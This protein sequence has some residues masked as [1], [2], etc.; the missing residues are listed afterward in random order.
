VRNLAALA[1]NWAYYRYQSHL[2][3][4][5]NT[6]L[7]ARKI[8][9]LLP[10]EALPGALLVAAAVAAMIVVNSPLGNAYQSV[11]DAP[12]LIGPS[13][14][15][16][17]MKL[18]YWIKNGLMAIFFFFVGL[19][20]KRELLEGQLSN[21]RAAVLP[22]LGA[23]GGMVAPAL[24]YIA[25]AGPAG[26]GHGWAIPAAT[27]IAFALGVLSLLGKRVP[28]ALKAFLLAVAVVDDLGAIVI[29]AFFYTEQVIV[30]PLVSSLAILAVAVIM[31]RCKVRFISAYIIIA[32]VLW[33]AMYQ[34]GISPTVT[35]V[36][37]A[38]CVPMH[39]HHDKSP[40]HKAEHKFRPWVMFGVMPIFAF[41]NAGVNL[42][43]AGAY[44]THPITLGTAF[45][46]I[47]GKP[48]GIT[49]MTYLGARTL[50]TPMPGS[51]VHVLGVACIA[52]IGFTMSLF[53]GA[54]A[55]KDPALATPIRLGVYAGS[56]V[57]AILGLVI[58]ASFLPK[59]LTPDQADDEDETAPFMKDEAVLG[60]PD[61]PD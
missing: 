2:K 43:G 16:I 61:V 6:T 18:S 4:N 14:S 49:I 25:L 29:V 53:I 15:G 35:G 41:A 20:L 21:L 55:F 39:H 33:V 52:G 34:S 45:G 26:F 58:L 37:I 47:F 17:E 7:P 11:L 46:L 42:T 60:D 50:R 36:L 51:F 44:L 38:A 13:G 9:G 57:S 12:L 54:L 5:M 32:L 22:M 1:A 31:N 40:L 28:P 19:E 24:I 27:D 48:V 30:A 3:A 10:Q 23:A 59:T 56:L 8:M